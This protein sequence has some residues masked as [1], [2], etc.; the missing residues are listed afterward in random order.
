M[1]LNKELPF[2]VVLWTQPRPLVSWEYS[3][4]HWLF[5]LTGSYVRVG[6][7]RP[8]STCRWCCCARRW[9]CWWAWSRRPTTACVWRWPSFYTTSSSSPSCGCWLRPCCSTSPS[10]RCWAPTFP[11]TPS[12]PCCP[13]GVNLL[14]LGPFQVV[15]RVSRS[16]QRGVGGGGGGK[17]GGGDRYYLKSHVYDLVGYVFLMPLPAVHGLPRD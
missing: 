4:A 15:N 9:W 16:L 12:R 2:H 7:S 10:S 14:M 8:C 11:S 6:P 3:R 13:P 17:R 1:T 5:A